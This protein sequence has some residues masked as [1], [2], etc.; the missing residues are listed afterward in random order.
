MTCRE[1]HRNGERTVKCP[2]ESCDEEVLARGINLHVRRSA[3]NGHGPQGEPPDNI[4]FDNLETVGEES[5]EMDY[6]EER[7]TEQVAR[8]C[9]YCGTPFTGKQGVLIHLGQ[10]AGRKNHPEDAADKHDP[11]DFPR[12][13]VDE[14][15]NVTGVI[16]QE[17][18]TEDSGTEP[19]IPA[20]RAYR[21]IAELLAENKP[22]EA[23]RA[24]YHLLRDDG[25]E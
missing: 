2:V 13:G 11:E 5:V 4:T 10:V 1:R 19:T 24:R 20:A 25:V 7:D 9:P 18:P 8:L 14:K 21:Y 16:E 3:G 22:E 12:V 15:E 6:P 23:Q 17:H